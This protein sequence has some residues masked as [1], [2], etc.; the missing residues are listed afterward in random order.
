MRILKYLE[1]AHL[2][3]YYFNPFHLFNSIMLKVFLAKQGRGEFA[4]K[5]FD[6]RA[7]LE[8]KSS[9]KTRVILFEY[10]LNLR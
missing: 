2:Q 8:S 7:L 3:R 1:E 6:K 5:T 10:N 4:V 9:E